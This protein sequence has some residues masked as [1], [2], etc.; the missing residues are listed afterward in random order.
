MTD[1]LI[2][3]VG[4]YEE[5]KELRHKAWSKI[6]KNCP[7]YEMAPKEYDDYESAYNTVRDKAVEIAEC[8]A[9]NIEG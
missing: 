6:P 9:K 3:L 5:A 1:E 4:E 8:V 2:K 7:F